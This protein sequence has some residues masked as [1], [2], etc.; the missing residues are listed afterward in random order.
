M[1]FL[2]ALIPGVR[3][4]RAPLIA[5]Y[6]WTFFGWLIANPA[7]P[8]EGGNLD[9]YDR[10]GEV[11]RSIGPVGQAVA[12][13][14][15][16]YLVGSV[17]TTIS[18][19]IFSWGI[20]TWR[21]QSTYAYWSSPVD[22]TG[23][24]PISGLQ[25]I[26]G[27]GPGLGFMPGWRGY[28]AGPEPNPPIDHAI[29]GIA[30]R[31]L[32]EERRRLEGALENLVEAAGSESISFQHRSRGAVETISLE[33]PDGQ[34]MTQREFVVPSFEAGRDLFDQ[35]PILRTRLVE[36]AEAIGMQVERI[37]SEVELR[38]AVAPPLLALALLFATDHL[39]WL[40]VAIAPI[41]LI[42]QALSLE[43]EGERQVIDALRARSGTDELEKL[44]PVFARY[45]SEA[46]DLTA[47]LKE[48]RWTPDMS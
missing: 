18:L 48:A 6:L 34:Q 26:A 38:L 2:S 36:Q 21:S 33:V 31:E 28:M 10:A 44:T 13:S 23:R 35:L 22:E 12:V 30:D 8:A 3:E 25:S 46:H 41:A 20:R 17:L 42:G 45:R 27:I 37:Y 47:A 32:G 4:I 39:L 24:L 29:L 14:V 19:K 1:A 9:L 40:L 15:A 7:E 5:G 11:A 16:A 43:Q